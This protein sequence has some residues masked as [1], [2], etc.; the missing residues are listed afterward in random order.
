MKPPPLFLFL[1]HLLL[2]LFIATNATKLTA[3]SPT[4]SPTP[5]TTSKSSTSAL[6]PQQI[7]ALQ[8]LHIPTTRD[9][10]IQ[11]SP[12]NATICDNSKPFRHLISLDLFNCSSDLSLSFTALKSLS[13][14]HSLSFTNCRASPIRFPSHLSLSLTSFSCIHSLRCLTGVW[15]SRFVNVTDLTVSYTSI[16]TH[17][18]Y[19]ILGNMHK[20]KTIT[21]SHAN[22]TGSLPRHLHLNL[23]HIDLSNNKLKGKIPTSLTLLEDLE[24]LNLSSN[25]LNGVIPTEFGD[26]ISLKNVS[27]AS[28]SFS[29][30]IPDSLS[31]IPGLVHVDLSNNQLNGTVPRFFSE[32]KE[33]KVLNLENNKLHGVLPFNASFI[34]RLDVLKVGGNGNLCY[35]HSVLSSKIK[36][37]I[38][39]CDKHGMPMLP[40]PT[41]ESSSGDSESES[42]DYDYD[43]DG[44]EGANEKKGHHHGPNKVVL[45]VAIGL[46]S[47]VFLIVFF[48]LLSKWCR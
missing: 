14:L 23:T 20:L 48:V 42:S 28:N 32:L 34:K 19:V 17:G 5:P 46:S 6:D 15:L 9:P 29:G 27:L 37:G 18:L 47:I 12:H 33:L 13:S 7:R 45:G 4:P 8:S 16:N 38:A 3:L 39:P 44:A 22:L 25:G 2:L 41:K 40:P 36:L 26:L 35:N 24:F 31:A 1:L 43:D 21:I 30:P 10:C 11:P